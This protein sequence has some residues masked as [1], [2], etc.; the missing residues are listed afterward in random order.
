MSIDFSRFF[1]ASIPNR[2][3]SVDNPQDRQYYIDFSTVRGSDIIKEL[4]RTILL[5]GGKPNCQLFTG[6][7]G[8]GKS[9]ELLRLK[10]ELEQEKYHVVYF[11]SDKDLD[12]G[13]VDV[14]DILLAIARQV[15]SSLEAIGINLEPPFFA[16]LFSYVANTLKIP[17]NITKVELSVGIAKIA[18]EAKHSPSVRQQLRAYIEPRTGGMLDAIN[19]ELLQPAVKRLQQKNKKGL[20]V[21]VD[22]LDRVDNIRKPSGRSQ[23][24]YLFLDRGEQLKKLECYLVYTVPLTLLFSGELLPLTNRFGGKPKLLPM[25]PVEH[26]D[27]SEHLEGLALLR[28]MVLARAFPT[29]NEI[30]RLDRIT[31]VFGH[32]S[33]LA[34][35]CCISGGHMR[36][37]MVLLN[38]CLQRDDPPIS[39]AV[40]ESVIRDF[41]DEFTL[42]VSDRQWEL[43]REIRKRKTIGEAPIYQELLRRLYIYEY[44]DSQG[45]W[46]DVNPALLEAKE[47]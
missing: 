17:L 11:E 47:F 23:P 31:D 34:R 36:H 15:S 12:I 35:L 27:G 10:Y 4:K 7:I 14:S 20:V 18:S 43:M 8:C 5:S 3:L 16:N 40:L 13:D 1:Q 44:R 45:R 39:R 9:T 19:Q 30:Q 29:L 21:I 24:E 41:R 26:N 25:V 6:H 37:L 28:Q 22:N 38:S 46:F 42:A 2:V 33:T 32:A